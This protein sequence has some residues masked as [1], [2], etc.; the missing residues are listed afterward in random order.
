MMDNSTRQQLP[1]VKISKPL[2]VLAFLFVAGTILW[3]MLHAK[4]E[5]TKFS[6][7]QEIADLPVYL[8]SAQTVKAPATFDGVAGETQV[9]Y[10]TLPTHVTPDST[11]MLQ[12]EYCS[13]EVY[14]DKELLGGYGTKLPLPFGEMVGNI[15][16]LVRIPTDCAGEQITIR[17][18]PYYDTKTDYPKLSYAAIGTLELYV[19]LHNMPR[20]VICLILLTMALA[21]ACMSIYEGFGG[22]REI[23]KMLGS[24]VLFVLCILTWIICSSD[25]PQFFTNQNETVSLISFIALSVLAIPFST[26]CSLVLKKG[27][28]AFRINAHIGWI[29][30]FTICLCFVTN[31]CDPYHLLI[32]TH[33]YIAATLLLAIFCALKQWREDRGVAILAASLILLFIFALIGLALFYISKTGGYDA[34]F[35]GGGLAL[36]ILM[37]FALILNRQMGYYEQKRA[38]EIYKEMA[39]S[40][41]LTKIPNRTAFEKRI[42]ELVEEKS[43]HAV[44]I[45][46]LDLN[47]LKK[48]NDHYGHQHGDT[49]IKAT[50][51]CLKK[52]FAGKGDHFRVGGDEFTAVVLD[53]AADPDE[54]CAKF[55]DYVDEYN[56]TAEHQI[57]VAIGYAQSEEMGDESSYRILFSNA[58]QEMY[59]DKVRLKENFVT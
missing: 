28:N 35:F 51:E 11:L 57:R 16:V 40:D 22:S 5:R 42:E 20:L 34:L 52:T 48:I 9:F 7:A 47:D 12:S 41:F 32:L 19:L 29:L 53:H 45:F 15:R 14:A 3:C 56:K 13:T 26:F 58:D 49:A 18:T 59:R 46:V 27:R 55:R 21:A 10:A 50:A 43:T 2:C 24:F 6:A 17:Y 44:T 23:M 25:F 31:I 54:C 30:P 39:L 36:F 38:A 4:N 1:L 37:L 33:V 8:D